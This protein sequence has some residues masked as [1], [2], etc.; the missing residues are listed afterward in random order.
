MPQFTLELT[1]DKN[2]ADDFTTRD[3]NIAKAWVSTRD[4][5][6]LEGDDAV[7]QLELSRDAMI[8]LGVSLIRWAHELTNDRF[9]AQELHPIEKGAI[10]SYLGVSLHPGSCKVVVSRHEFG[11]VEALVGSESAPS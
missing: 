3:S 10:Y 8:G 2:A 7:I 9:S 4:G 6:R 5:E 1:P 11:T